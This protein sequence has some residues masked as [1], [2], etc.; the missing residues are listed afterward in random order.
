MARDDAR[1]QANARPTDERLPIHLLTGFL[2]AGKTTLLNRYLRL[3]E[4]GTTAILVNEF[5]EMDVDGAVLA[6]RLG[7]GS[8]VLSLPNGCVCCAVQEDLAAALIGLIARRR[9]GPGA[10]ERCVIETTGLADPGAIIRG[11]GHDPRLRQSAFV[12]QTVTVC[13]ADRLAGQLSRFPEPARQIGIADRIVVTKCD[14]ATPEQRDA[15]VARI[16]A[17]NPLAELRVAGDGRLDPQHVFTA[18]AA[19]AV[20]PVETATD[21]HHHHASTVRSFVVRSE[22]PLDPDRFRDVLSFLIMRHAESI[23]RIKGILRFAG[24]GGAR[25]VNGVHDVFASEPLGGAVPAAPGGFL[26]FIGIDLPERSIRADLASC[27]ITAQPAGS[28]RG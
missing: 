8:R 13:A 22:A 9:D 1:P 17:I 10:I 15:S 14:L 5:G 11:V 6:A 28:I 3:P 27:E 25:L 2:G 16:A 21:S 18:P 7:D 4:A 24:E 12:E 20:R 26:V 23:L 19:D